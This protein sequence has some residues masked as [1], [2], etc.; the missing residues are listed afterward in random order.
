MPEGRGKCDASEGEPRIQDLGSG[1]ESHLHEQVCYLR[2]ALHG[3]LCSYFLVAGLTPGLS[4]K[5][6]LFRSMKF[7]HLSGVSSSVKIAGFVLHV[8]AWLGDDIRHQGL[9]FSSA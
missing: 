6:C 2:P 9:P 4:L 5:N 1:G 8:D 3:S 7:F